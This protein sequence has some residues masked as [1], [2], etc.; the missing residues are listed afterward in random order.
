MSKFIINDNKSIFIKLFIFFALKVL[1][2]YISFNI[3]NFYILQLM[4]KLIRKKSYIFLKLS[5]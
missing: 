3:I 4:S 1:Y 5:N 2:L